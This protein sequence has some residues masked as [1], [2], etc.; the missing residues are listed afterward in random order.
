[1]SSNVEVPKSLLSM[2][3]QSE[4]VRRVALEAA[5]RTF[6]NERG[7]PNSIYLDVRV[8][9]WALMNQLA[10]C[11]SDARLPSF[12][13]AMKP[14]STVLNFFGPIGSVLLSET[15]P[16][17]NNLI[18]QYLSLFSEAP[19]TTSRFDSVR[20]AQRDIPV[21]APQ[22]AFD[23]EANVVRAFSALPPL[24]N[25]YSRVAPPIVHGNVLLLNGRVDPNTPN[26]MNMALYG[27]LTV[28]NG[29]A[30]EQST[31]RNAGHT[32]ISLGWS[33]CTD[34]LIE[35]FYRHNQTA[36]SAYEACRDSENNNT[37]AWNATELGIATQ[38][39][40][41]AGLPDA[42]AFTTTAT[43]T[44]A[45][46]V[47]TPPPTTTLVTGTQVTGTQVTGT[48]VTGTQV[49]GTQVTGTQVTGTQVTGTQVTGTQVTGTQVTGTQA[50]G[51]QVTGTQAT[52][53]QATGTPTATDTTT[54]A[55]TT[56]AAP[57]NEPL[58]LWKMNISEV[59]TPGVTFQKALATA[60]GVSEDMIVLQS[61]TKGPAYDEVSFYF[62]GEESS[63]VAAQ[64]SMV[65]LDRTGSLYQRLRD[66]GYVSRGLYAA[67]GNPEVGAGEIVA[68][69]CY[70]VRGARWSGAAWRHRVC[71]LDDD[72]PPSRR[73]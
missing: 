72:Q 34:L 35:G 28:A 52:G 37:F 63:A 43:T 2:D 23:H 41:W 25:R 9:L 44:A 19:L 6:R 55:P 26:S 48:Q 45:T 39:S 61:R 13:E 38:G 33:F 60:L 14:L 70:H 49:T 4:E 47:P 65:S 73:V 66:N 7:M 67:E 31:H 30:K 27:E 22:G 17:G 64:R 16:T 5:L 24:T 20:E 50:T 51:T 40:I 56:T 8:I 15:S 42:N 36:R 3:P 18:T 69:A 58:R 32:V 46:T 54:T 62:R 12:G 29:Y 59:G 68:C 21:R 1:M 11:S 57:T 71:S 53:T 10:Q